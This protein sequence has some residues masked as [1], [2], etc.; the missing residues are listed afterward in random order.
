MSK[1]SSS[2]SSSKK[3]KPSGKAKSDSEVQAYWNANAPAAALSSYMRNK[4][5]KVWK[6]PA[7]TL[8][9]EYDVDIPSVNASEQEWGDKGWHVHIILGVQGHSRVFPYLPS[10]V[11]HMR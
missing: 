9:P 2:S 10:L 8:D 4:G 6:Y 1:S 7:M 11:P 3:K 5:G